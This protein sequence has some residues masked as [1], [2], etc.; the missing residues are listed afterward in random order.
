MKNNFFR[1]ELTFAIR[2]LLKSAKVCE[3]CFFFTKINLEARDRKQPLGKSSANLSRNLDVAKLNA[4]EKSYLKKI[5][6]SKSKHIFNLQYTTVLWQNDKMRKKDQKD[7]RFG[8][9][10]RF[11]IEAWQHTRNNQEKLESRQ[12]I[13]N[14]FLNF[15]TRSRINEERLIL[16]SVSTS[17][18]AS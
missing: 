4:G 12:C 18:I 1:R 17:Y 10:S 15:K 8:N 11:V 5:T 7:S 2:C 16:S 13:E 9:Y 3:S 14:S 6:V